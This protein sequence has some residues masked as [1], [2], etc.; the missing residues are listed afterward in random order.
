MRSG[1][2]HCSACF[3]L[4]LE[5]LNLYLEENVKNLL[6]RSLVRLREQRCNINLDMGSEMQHE[7]RL[8][9][10]KVFSKSLCCL[11]KTIKKICISVHA[12]CY[13][14]L[15]QTRYLMN[16]RNSFLTLLEAGKS[17]I[18]AIL[19]WGVSSWF[20]VGAFWLCPH[21]GR[22]SAELC[23]VSFMRTVIT[24]TRDPLSNLST[25]HKSTS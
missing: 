7:G 5:R 17:K 6:M 25:W 23:G 10:T 9:G 12:D 2:Q 19:W 20:I 14:K 3:L 21:G 15:P 8:L 16:D 4:T 24:L 11:K 1:D 18:K 22:S 13:N